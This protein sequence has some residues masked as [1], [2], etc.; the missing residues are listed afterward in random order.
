MAAEKGGDAGVSSD[1]RD[2]L[3]ARLAM[4][5]VHDAAEAA[6]VAPPLVVELAGTMTTREGAA[7]LP[8]WGLARMAERRRSVVVVMAAAAVEVAKVVEAAAAAAMVAQVTYNFRRSRH[9]AFRWLGKADGLL[10]CQDCYRPP[11]VQ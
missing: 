5:F 3:S 10:H 1:P 2:S 11:A 8:C 4:V 9:R 6:A 7:S